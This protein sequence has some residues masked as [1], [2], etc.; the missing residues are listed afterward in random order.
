MRLSG[1]QHK[2]A[3]AWTLPGLLAG[4]WVVLAWVSLAR[5]LGPEQRE[6]LQ[7]CVSGMLPEQSNTS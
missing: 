7:P 3:V 6:Q 2:A 4:Y 1:R 5:Q